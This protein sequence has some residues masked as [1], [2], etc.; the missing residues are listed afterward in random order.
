[1][2]RRI[3]SGYQ[4]LGMPLEDLI[5]EGTVGLLE[6]I[7]QYDPRR[8]ASFESFARFRIRRAIR[9]ALTDKARLIRLP[10][11]IV[12]RRR[13]LEHV[14]AR[15]SAA[16]SGRPPTSS[17]L[18]A[19]TGLPLR[20][21]NAARRAPLAPI[22]LD[23]PVL[24]EGGSLA[25]LIA[26]PE[27]ADPELRLLEAEQRT[28]LADSLQS[29]STRE[30]QVVAWRFGVGEAPTS[31]ADTA[32]RLGLSPRRAQTIQRDALY[33]LRRSIAGRRDASTR[34]P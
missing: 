6:A 5:Q 15:L 14:E 18:A 31:N 23:Q 34:A 16:A 25:D 33:R 29:L 10:K 28:I 13:A 7:D 3:A 2:V 9:N 8:G 27:A 22:S 24:P 1:M 30:R 26:D 11:Q 32:R 17:E 19:A 12:E 20:A 4:E 21:V